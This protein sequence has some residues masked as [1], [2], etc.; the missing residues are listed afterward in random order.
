MA[1]L[2]ASEL[3][4]L[5]GIA[6]KN[7]FVY[8]TRKKLVRNPEKL[9]DDSDPVNKI[10]LELHRKNKT[11][12]D[13]LEGKSEN[14]GN[15]EKQKEIPSFSSMDLINIELKKVNIQKTK[16]DIELKELEYKQLK[17]S[18]IELEQTINLVTH[19]SDNLKRNLQQ[20]V[21][22]FIQD[23]CA[24]HN[25]EPGKAGEYKLNVTSL[26]NKA[27]QSSIDILLN[28]FKNEN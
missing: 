14:N 27:N 13:V 4:K 21:Q 5:T 24:R 15:E 18:L 25:I 10:F 20:N 23:I 9:Y 28:H 26:I 1:L 17:G 6:P 2:T 12:N 7:I 22:T 16:K 8:K 11:E 19:Y 3:G